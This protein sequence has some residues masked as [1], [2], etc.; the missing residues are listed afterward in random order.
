MM[1]LALAALSR[2]DFLVSLPAAEFYEKFPYRSADDAYAFVEATAERNPESVL[3]SLEIWGEKYPMFQ[4][5]ATKGAL[6]DDAVRSAKPRVAVEIGSFLG[7]SAVRIARLLPSGSSLTCFEASPD[8]A[9]VAKAVLEYARLDDVSVVVAKG[10]EAASRMN[11]R[12]VD[13]LF[14]DHAKECYAPDLANFERAGLVQRGTVVLADNVKYP[15]APGYL[16]HLASSGYSQVKMLEA[17]Y[18]SVGWET[19]WKKV[20]DAMALSVY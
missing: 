15:G 14:L 20:D 3:E 6:L 16:E 19:S 4:I 13:F 2:R 8:F 12:R 7:Y 18:E 11:E 5:G 17:P 1:L 10:S 9:R